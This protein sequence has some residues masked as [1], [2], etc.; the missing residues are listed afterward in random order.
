M[1]FL[2]TSSKFPVGDAVGAVVRPPGVPAGSCRLLEV[3]L[4]L[5][6]LSD[7]CRA[8]VELLLRFV[9]LVVGCR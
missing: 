6:L 5:R 1:Q 7:T 3:L 8:R 2:W 9:N 4:H